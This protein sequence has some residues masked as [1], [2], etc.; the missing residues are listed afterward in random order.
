VGQ[1]ANNFACQR[2]GVACAIEIAHDF[3]AD[4][5]CE[6]TGMNCRLTKRRYSC[7]HITAD[8]RLAY[9]FTSTHHLWQ[10]MPTNSSTMIIYL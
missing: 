9:R 7:I 5:W 3:Y 1:R 6:V 10:D 8:A 4:S 2:V